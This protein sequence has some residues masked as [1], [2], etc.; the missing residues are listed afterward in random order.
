MVSGSFPF[1][2]QATN[3]RQLMTEFGKLRYPPTFSPMLVDLLQKM[4]VVKPDDRPTLMTL[5]GH[6]WLR[7]L[8]QLGTNIAPS[9][10]VFQIARSLAA[11]AK[12]R[13]RKTAPRPEIL[14]KC[15]QMG[16][17]VETLKNSLVSGET[18][19]DTTT[20]FVLCNPI[21]E[22]P[23]IVLAAP[24]EPPEPEPA[25]EGGL[26]PLVPRGGKRTAGGA[27]STMSS[28]VRVTLGNPAGRST[29]PGLAPIALVQQR[30][31]SKLK[32]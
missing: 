9:P 16:I 27:G 8:E 7:G 23:V 11:I 3:F 4:L 25:K 10:I 13:R 20:Y 6:P 14:A 31:A 2:S 5:Q 26:P 22:R 29:R 19:S 21:A 12:F 30:T 1:S 32:L 17:D 24:E 28:K 18:T 15:E